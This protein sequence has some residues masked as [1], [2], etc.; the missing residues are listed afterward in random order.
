MSGRISWGKGSAMALLVATLPLTM[1]LLSAQESGKCESKQEGAIQATSEDPKGGGQ[2]AAKETGNISGVVQYALVKKYPAVVFIEE[3]PGR[4]FAP[5]EKHSI[6][7]QLGKVFVPRALPVVVGTTVDFLNSDELEHNVFSP[8]NEKYD[9]GNWGK[10]E[11]R[12]YTFNR[13]GAYTQLCSLHPEM[14]AYVVACK[15]PYFA[16][17]DAEGKFTIKDVPVGSWKLKVWHERLKPKQLEKTFDVTV[18]LNKE[19]KCTIEP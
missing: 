11:K 16:V 7:D 17:A 2:E 15:T 19:A 8:D 9:L 12:V 13:P 1:L 10:G 6:M 14:I 18:E 5:P 4:T 3:M